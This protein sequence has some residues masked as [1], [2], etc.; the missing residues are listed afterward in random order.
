MEKIENF[1]AVNDLCFIY[2]ITNEEI[3]K[4]IQFNNSGCLVVDRETTANFFGPA[5]SF[6]KTCRRTFTLK[7][8]K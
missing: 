3:T 5:W 2:F 7:N 4:T 8:K 1:N 6:Y